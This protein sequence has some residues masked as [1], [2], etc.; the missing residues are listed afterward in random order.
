MRSRGGEHPPTEE[1]LARLTTAAL[2]LQRGGQINEPPMDHWL[3]AVNWIIRQ[4]VAETLLDGV[5]GGEASLR[6]DA[7]RLYWIGP[8]STWIDLGAVAELQGPDE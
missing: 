4:E 2:A 5:R 6:V 7:G 8:R 1:D 3:A